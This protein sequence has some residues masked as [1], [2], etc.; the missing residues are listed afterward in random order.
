MA[1]IVK[2]NGIL[3]EYLKIQESSG[4]YPLGCSVPE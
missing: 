2:E 1:N 4:P 3:I